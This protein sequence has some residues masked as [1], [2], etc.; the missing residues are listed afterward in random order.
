[1]LFKYF[2]NSRVFIACIIIS[3]SCL[4][5][6]SQSNNNS[7]IIG[8]DSIDQKPIGSP[9]IFSLDT[10]F[11]I[12]NK[13]G[14][15]SAVERAKAIK[16]RI[17]KLA[18]DFNYSTDSLLVVPDENT[19]DIIYGKSIII[20]I[21][22]DDAKIEKMEPKQL[23]TN[24]KLHINNV[25][26]KY[27][28]STGLKS[29]I[30]D[31][32]LIFIIL[33]ALYWVIKY[34][35]KFFRF[36][37]LKI[38]EWKGKYIKGIKIRDY[39]LFTARNEVRALVIFNNIIHWVILILLIYLSLPLIFNILPWTKGFS[40]TLLGFIFDPLK[41]M[42]LA[43]WH[44][45]P[46]L[47]TI[48]VILFVFRYVLKGLQFLKKEIEREALHIPGFYPDWANPTYQ[49]IRVLIFAFMLILIFPYLPGSNSPVFQG[50]SVFLGFL[51]TFGSSGSLSN[52]IAGLVL[53]YMRSFK[54]G[55]RVKIGEVTGDIIEKSLLVTRIRTIKNEDITIPNSTILNSH[56][57]NYSSS[58]QKS[59]LILNT[60]VTIGYD[61]PWR[62]VHQLL[63]DAAKSTEFILKEP[64]PFVL[65]TSL[66]DFFVSYQINA[67]TNEPN[68]QATIYSQL[69]Q[70]IQDKFNEAGVEIMS[71][72]YSSIRDGN[73]TTIPSDYLPGDYISPSFK[74]KQNENK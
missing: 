66:D 30:I 54:I 38:V 1:M 12:Y 16:L 63:I 71:S 10:L 7:K 34:I 18:N 39:E 5:T 60:T 53:T 70:N 2:K 25:I 26:S 17:D 52:V 20:S 46:N 74:V 31:F 36:S 65:Q 62:Q 58:S 55:D 40:D 48:I 50:V 67:Y 8:I 32:G 6:F 4:N 57:I 72:H 49:I 24:Y 29:I 51:L 56:T 41:K 64:Q 68:K 42:F 43:L 15:F 23:A 21:N 44:Y 11:Y 14:S 69:H 37:R 45:L 47:F 19:Y 3:F 22:S 9:V 35:N 28:N 59:G 13:S 27:R 33:I 61:A 73:Q